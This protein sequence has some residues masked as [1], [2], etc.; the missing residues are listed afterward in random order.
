MT[1]PGCCG[2]TAGRALGRSPYGPAVSA[3]VL[4][5]VLAAGVLAWIGSARA[6]EPPAEPPPK[7]P[8][9]LARAGPVV[10]EEN[11]PEA[12]PPQIEVTGF[13][14]RGKRPW[15]RMDI[16]DLDVVVTAGGQ[17]FLPLLR[18]LKIFRT[19]V[20]HED[21]NLVF[22]VEG[23][24]KTL[25]NVPARRIRFEGRE[26]A[27][28]LIE[29][30]SD[31]TLQ[32]EVYLPV[33]VIAEILAIGIEWDDP[34]YAFN[35]TIERGLKMWEVPWISP[36]DLEIY[37]EP[38]PERFP[39]AYPPTDGLQFMELEG[40]AR[41]VLLEDRQSPESLVFGDFRQTLWGNFRGGHYKLRFTEPTRVLEREGWREVTADDIMLNWGEYV[42][43]FP[44][45]E[46][47]FGDSQFGL[48]N[49]V[50]P[51][52]RLTGV[53]LNGIVGGPPVRGL[54]GEPSPGLRSYFVQPYDF[55]GYALAGSR[56]QLFINDRLVEEDVIVG[57]SPNRPGKGAYRFEDIRLSPGVLNDVR[58]VITDPDGVETQIRKNIV[59]TS[60]LLPEG[61][62]TWLVASGF[63]R[64][65]DR[66]LHAGHLTAARAN[67]G[68]A[69][70]LAVGT[71]VAV[72]D[73]FFDFERE[74]VLP[75]ADDRYPGEGAHVG[76]NAH[77]KPLEW[78]LLSA[79]TAIT[80]AND[81]S[82]AFDEWATELGAHVFPIQ[83]LRLGTS[84]FRYSP[85]F[86]DGQNID[87]HDRE[88]WSM[89]G[90]WQAHPQW[91]FDVGAGRFHNNLDGNL[92]DTLAV[93]FQHAEVKTYVIPGTE[94]A[95]ALDRT[96]ANTAPDDQVLWTVRGRSNLPDQ[97]ILYGEVLF[98]DFLLPDDDPDF[99]SG[100][101][102]PT[103]AI[104]RG[105]AASAF[106]TRNLGYHQTVGGRY[107]K[108]GTRQRASFLHTYR[109]PGRRS[110]QTRTEIG[111]DI[112][113][114]GES[115]EDGRQKMFLENR[116]EYLTDLSGRN[117]F[118][119]LTRM[120]VDEWTVMLFANL[121]ARYA[122]PD[123]RPV[124]IT[125][126]GI[127]PDRGGVHGKVFVD[128]NA[129]GTLDE[130][131]PGLPDVKVR[132]RQRYPAT[133]DADGYYALPGLRAQRETRVSIDMATV[134]AL[135]TPTH[136]TQM[137]D[138]EPRSL[139]RV[140][141]GV[142]PA[143]TVVGT[144]VGIEPGKEPHPLAGVRIM[145][146]DRDTLALAADSVTAGDGSYYLD[147]VVTGRYV[148]R[149]D[150]IS[151]PKRYAMPDPVRDLEIAPN[152]EVQDLTLPPIEIPLKE[153]K[154]E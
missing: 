55:E 96:L 51:N 72:H 83:D 63:A 81:N 89:S 151:V 109:S 149:L 98:G 43:Q 37:E 27:V 50:F 78:L 102:L 19:E 135:Y 133:T 14:L 34:N 139:T 84:Y 107:F 22:Q 47:A 33:D 85:G 92:A 119:L 49:L 123:R 104:Y 143:N 6:A 101:H 116:I 2:P 41:A 105:P 53:R 54:A 64:R 103:L 46:L 111:M 127:H 35:A 152:E 106:L 94:L 13:H 148:I 7:A 70:N 69:D 136:G 125:N 150:P 115:E 129:N 38:L 21:R 60:Q 100:I 114:A 97:W 140:D 113:R 9:A 65:L 87:L 86:F 128:L 154:P 122:F 142:A 120:E 121:N 137:V 15:H 52:V 32:R 145:L 31:I 126:T 68:V 75:A 28:E 138:I 80:N 118:G 144:I 26:D 146:A 91:R 48:S 67:Y 71:S 108:S 74:D 17:R 1:D 29:A 45:A 18:L 57:D 112:F 117:R 12:E 8:E 24:P 62:M 44:Y 25:L 147:N 39:M 5:A 124:R 66:W 88:G 73:G 77:Y 93:D 153:P 40:A 79:E 99:F 141:L 134:G 36:W 58:I 42:Y 82:D 30:I 10:S 56:V 3:A 16:G 20:S 95:V 61:T 132:L 76:L 110:L 23:G 130:G 4:S 131:E 11:P 90:T 59:P